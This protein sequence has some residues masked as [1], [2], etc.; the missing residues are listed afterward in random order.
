LTGFDLRLY[1]RAVEGITQ[2]P[3]QA[4]LE[5]VVEPAISGGLI[6]YR[7]WPAR[8]HVGRLLLVA[9]TCVGVTA[10]VALVAD[11][12]WAVFVLIGVVLGAGVFFFPT[13]VALDSYTLHVRSFGTPR[14]WD[15]RHFRRFEVSGQPFSRVELITRTGFDLLDNVTFPVPPS[16]EAILDHLRAWVGRTPTG[17]F[18]LD[19]DMVPEDTL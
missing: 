13:E 18:E 8:R 5:G 15:L 14:T 19:D 16:H 11:T 4:D 17:T 12:F 9:G 2:D 10:A 6:R 7:V 3:A 1:R